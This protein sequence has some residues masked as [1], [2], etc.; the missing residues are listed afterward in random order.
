MSPTY[1]F[2]LGT[3][4]RSAGLPGMLRFDTAAGSLAVPLPADV[5]PRDIVEIRIASSD[6][7]R[8]IRERF[9]VD[10]GAEHVAMKPPVEWLTPGIYRV[11]R[12]VIATD[13]SIV[14][15]AEFLVE[16]Q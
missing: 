12:R 7:T 9:A 8:E 3:G 11:E 1:R 4:D 6:G 16:I 14:R 13:T 10:A 15:T 5:G 2:S